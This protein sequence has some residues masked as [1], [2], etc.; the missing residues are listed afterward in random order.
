MAKCTNTNKVTLAVC[1]QTLVA[2]KH[3]GHRIDPSGYPAIEAIDF[4]ASNPYGD[5]IDGFTNL[6]CE[7]ADCTQRYELQRVA[8]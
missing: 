6:M 5:K 4:D 1:D 8:D 7:H 3:E 2:W